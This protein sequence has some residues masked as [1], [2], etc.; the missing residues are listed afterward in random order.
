VVAK[1]MVQ[2]LKGLSDRETI[3]ALRR[4][5]AWLVADG[6]RPLRALGLTRQD[7]TW[8]LA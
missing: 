6:C 3:S 7:K 8:V 2:A 4:D 5:I 1:V